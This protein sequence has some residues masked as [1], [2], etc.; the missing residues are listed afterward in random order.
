MGDSEE[1]TVINVGSSVVNVTINSVTDTS[2]NATATISYFDAVR[3]NGTRINGHSLYI[4]VSLP[5]K[6]FVCFFVFHYNSSLRA[7]I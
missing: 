5:S 6:L 7:N 2:I 4:T 1:V 3:L